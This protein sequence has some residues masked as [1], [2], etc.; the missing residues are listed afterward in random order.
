VDR[1][2]G[3]GGGALFARGGAQDRRRGGGQEPGGKSRGEGEAAGFC[4]RGKEMEE[5]EGRE[6]KDRQRT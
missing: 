3:A 1:R 2:G 5:R 4:V 6:K